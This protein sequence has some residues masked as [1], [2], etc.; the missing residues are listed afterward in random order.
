[1]KESRRQ[2]G[3]N[4]MSNYVR[5]AAYVLAFAA[6]PAMVQA[7]QAQ[8]S[9]ASSVEQSAPG[10][11]APDQS[12]ADQSAAGQS[13]AAEA[14]VEAKIAAAAQA[15]DLAAAEIA[16]AEAAEAAEAVEAAE[17]AQARLAA[18]QS[19]QERIDI[20]ETESGPY[21][22]NL[23]EVH[24]DLGRMYQAENLHQEA[25]ASFANALQLVRISE[26]LYSERQIAVLEQLISVNLAAENWAD[27]DDNHH[28]LF[29]IKKQLYRP[30][31]SQVLTSQKV[32]NQAVNSQIVNSQADN[33]AWAAAV[34]E[35]G[36]WNLHASRSNLM[37][38]SSAM[39]AQEI[40]E[41]HALYSDAINDITETAFSSG[42]NAAAS[43]EPNADVNSGLAGGSGS[44]GISDR[45]SLVSLLYG[46]ARAEHEIA[47]T[48]MRMPA[49]F[50]AG[51]GSPYTVRTVCFPVAASI[52][53]A[54]NAQA[55]FLDAAY[56]PGS[57]ESWV[58]DAGITEEGGNPDLI[59]AQTNSGPV[60]RV[61]T[62]ERVEN[63]A[64]RASQR[65]EQRMRLDRAAMNMRATIQDLQ[66]ILEP[67]IR[68]N[69]IAQ[70][71]RERLTELNQMQQ[72]LVR[73][74]RR[75]ISRWGW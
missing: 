54:Q 30:A 51:Q 53:P 59:L 21:A 49:D 47:Q 31:N 64:Y 6:L 34:I 20:L 43:G 72:A 16:A 70:V 17:V 38:R 12:D 4:S 57:T 65:S 40:E 69:S 44:V 11:S 55:V 8:E 23:I 63:P 73:D 2:F 3:L 41:V 37:R 19:L 25:A 5:I 71:H 67:S 35:F 52:A 42:S 28:L 68:D 13:D 29:Q 7:A 60:R 26:G 1:M 14:A 62:S 18:R 24:F 75:S 56:E 27:V 33:S 32:P 66:A 15:A 50:F 46:K 10:Q 58:D 9:V 36:E 22:A 48:V 45:A 39:H 61:C 74:S